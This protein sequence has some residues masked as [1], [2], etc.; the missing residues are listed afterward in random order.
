MLI[1]L[2]LLWSSVSIGQEAASASTQEAEWQFSSFETD[3]V[4]KKAQIL[5]VAA[6]TVMRIAP[7]LQAGWFF[8]Q[9]DAIDFTFIGTVFNTPSRAAPFNIH[10]ARSYWNQ[11]SLGARH[12]F[13]KS[14]YGGL[15]WIELLSGDADWIAVRR[16]SVAAHIGNEIVNRNGFSAAIDWFGY[17]YVTGTSVT[18]SD[19]YQQEENADAAV[20]EASRDLARQLKVPFTYLLTLKLGYTFI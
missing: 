12:F 14:F 7:G 8:T 10:A 5:F 19:A 4:E 2:L 20:G 13:G 3:E 9:S 16:S 11:Y 1:S 6:P 17:D 15:S 18:K